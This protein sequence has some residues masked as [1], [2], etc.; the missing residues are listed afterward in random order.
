MNLF[1]RFVVVSGT[2]NRSKRHIDNAY[3]HVAKICW[4]AAGKRRR[5]KSGN[6][7]VGD[8]AEA[9]QQ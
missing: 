2:M 9:A 1:L 3:G 5:G 6:P 8:L 7:Q 4:A